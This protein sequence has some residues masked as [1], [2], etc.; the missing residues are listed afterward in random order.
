MEDA[1]PNDWSITA[2]SLRVFC[3]IRQRLRAYP[4]QATGE[5]DCHL[6][7][8]AQQVLRAVDGLLKSRLTSRLSLPQLL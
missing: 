5:Q 7:I 3:Y 6:D 8:Q 2:V 1:S 4:D